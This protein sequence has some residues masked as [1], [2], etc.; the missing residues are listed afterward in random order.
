MK[1]R[2]ASQHSL[3]MPNNILF[4][5][6]GFLFILFFFLNAPQAAPVASSYLKIHSGH[7]SSLQPAR[8]YLFICL[9]LH[10]N[11]TGSPKSTE[12]KSVN[13]AGDREEKQGVF[14]NGEQD[15]EGR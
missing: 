2:W 5:L 10:M 7:I 1:K 14:V 15:T 8:F 4:H 13:Q 9:S 3:N 12:R 6:S 11:K